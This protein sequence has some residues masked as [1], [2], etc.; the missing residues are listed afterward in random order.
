MRHQPRMRMF[1]FIAMRMHRAIVLDLNE[2]LQL[3]LVAG[4]RMNAR[5]VQAD[6]IQPRRVIRS[7][8]VGQYD[9]RVLH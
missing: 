3:K 9:G 2:V 8:P 1:T 7:W 4:S 5:F 6:Q